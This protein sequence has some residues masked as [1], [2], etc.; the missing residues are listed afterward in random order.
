MQAAATLNGALVSRLFQS[1]HSDPVK[2][3]HYPAIAVHRNGT[4]LHVN[5]HF[6]DASG[7]AA[8]EIEG[9]S[10]WTSFVDVQ[11]TTN[12]EGLLSRSTSYD[13]Q[14]HTFYDFSFVSRNRNPERAIIEVRPMR[15]GEQYLLIFKISNSRSER[16]EAC[17]DEPHLKKAESFIESLSQMIAYRDPGTALHER[18]VSILSAAI[19]DELHLPGHVSEGIRA[20][21]LVHDIG[22]IHV[23]GDILS[24]PSALNAAER[25]LVNGHARADMR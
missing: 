6:V 12:Y 2:E 10:V 3:S 17:H 15:G 5:R 18:R 16:V 11:T 21:A 14:S 20:A 23:P 7:Y 25:E 22:K 4:I 8:N 1:F 9:R 24:K 13:S 19:A